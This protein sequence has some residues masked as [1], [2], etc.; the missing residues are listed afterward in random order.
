MTKAI[1]VAIADNYAIGKGN[2]LLWHLS[3]DL[4]YF[5]RVTSG[6]PVIMGY[7]TF[8]SIGRPLPGRLN[9][10]ST[11]Y[12]FDAPEGVAVV[13]SLNEAYAVAEKHFDLA[14]TPEEDRVVFVIGGGETYRNALPEADLLYI[15]H[16]HTSVE[17][18]DTYFPVIDPRIWEKASEEAP[19]TDPESG[20]T[21]QFTVYKR[22]SIWKEKNSDPGS[23]S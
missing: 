22:T 20:L 21:Y 23:P 1:I 4:K 7:M 11:W 2:A 12:P 9:I 15:T 13:Y 17:D 6:H 18:A 16:V 19:A 10:V 8:K 5:K 14:E 3:E